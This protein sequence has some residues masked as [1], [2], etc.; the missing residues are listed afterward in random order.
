M[1]LGRL[2]IADVRERW[3]NEKNKLRQEIKIQF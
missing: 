1:L 3:A 2:Q